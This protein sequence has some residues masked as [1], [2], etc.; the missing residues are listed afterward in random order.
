VE[1]IVDGSEGLIPDGFWFMEMNTRLQVEHPVTEA[2]TGIDLVEW[3]LR[4]AAGEPL[5]RRQDEIAIS[6]HAFEARLYA[7]DPARGFLPAIGTLTHLD[8]PAD[9]RVD[10]GVRAGD[11]ISPWYDPMIAKL[12][13]HGPTRAT[14]LGALA[15]ALEVSRVAGSV[16]NL[17]FLAR[18]ARQADFV[19]GRID[20]GLIERNLEALAVPAPLDDG[21]LAIA[22][23]AAEGLEHC[24]DPLTGFVLWE[25]LRRRVVLEAND[26]LHDVVLEVRGPARFVAAGRNVVIEN[27]TGGEIACQI[28]GSARRFGIARAPGSL[29]LFDGAQAY[30][31]RLPDPLA[32]SGD[33]HGGG[34]EIRAPMPGVVR[35]VAIGLGSVVAAGDVLVVLE[36]MKMEHALTAPRDGKVA[37]VLV[38]AGE[39]VSDGNVMIRLESP[40]D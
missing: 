12:V 19:A 9:A 7:E 8:F 11:A 6:G 22:A 14:A 15:R 39:R 33:A 27:A 29:T 23:I 32:Q 28:D 25:P 1:F 37:E 35:H 5:P 2:I 38:A 10:S 20:T 26:D 18:L 16:T 24:T 31:F 36:A 13:V 4:V 40:D 34:D 30:V 17:G 3:Q 21:L